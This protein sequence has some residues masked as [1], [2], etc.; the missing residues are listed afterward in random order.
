M[1]RSPIRFNGLVRQ[2]PITIPERDKRIILAMIDAGLKDQQ[3]LAFFSQPGRDFNHNRISR[4]RK[5]PRNSGLQPASTVELQSFLDRW[6][7][8]SNL[9]NLFSKLT[10]NRDLSRQWRVEYRFHPV[11]QGMLHSG[12]LRNGHRKSINWIYDC[13]SVTSNKL[14]EDALDNIYEHIKEKPGEKPLIDIVALSHFDKDHVSGIVYLLRI[15]RVDIIILPFMPLWQR[16]WIAA[17][18]KFDVEFLRFLLDPA[19][20]LRNAA[21]GD[22]PRIVFVPPSD[23]T[24]PPPIDPLPD[25]DPGPDPDGDER[26]RRFPE[27]ADGRPLRIRVETEHRPDLL[28]GEIPGSRRVETP[29]AE[30]LRRGSVLDV[31]G[32]WEFVPYN[33]ANQAQKCPPSF[34]ASVEPLIAALQD[35]TTSAETKKAFGAL[36]RHYD[37]TFGKKNRNIISMFLYGGPATKPVDANFSPEFFFESTGGWAKYRD[38]TRVS[39]D[40]FAVLLTGDGSLNSSPR[41]TAFKNYFSPHGRLSKAAIFQV[42][43]HGASGNSSPEVAEMVAPRASIFCSDP[44]KGKKHPH[45]DVVRQFWEYNC[46]QVDARRGWMLYGTFEF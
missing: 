6:A 29:A 12:N 2:G 31:E 7:A 33:D 37:K 3:I 36:K 4:L 15:F 40:H 28:S 9:Q 10:F 44:T 27:K 22:Q 34:P 43:H 41:R 19:E 8:S 11:G 38:Y 18:D 16:L 17:A 26:E 32:F 5:A 45:A 1:T 13:G 42:M 35:A 20:F 23:D 24:P 46:V 25:P 30:F 39:T 14:V 21:G